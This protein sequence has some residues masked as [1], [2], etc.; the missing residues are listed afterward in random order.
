M[1]PFDPNSPA[2]T[3]RRGIVLMCVAVVF[4]TV[5]S[6]FVK[7]LGDGYPVAQIVFFRCL[8]GLLPLYFALRRA[9]GWA[10]L[11]TQRPGAHLFRVVVG[12]FALFIGFYALTLMPLADYFAYTYAAPLFATMLS[13]PVLGEKVGIRRWSAVTVGFIGVLIMLRPGMKSFDYATLAAIAT[14]FSYALAI[15]AVR[16]LARTEKSVATVFY[17][18]LAGMVLAGAMLPFDWRPPTAKEWALL[19]GIGLA[20]GIGQIVMAE[21]YRLA[22]PAVIAPFDYTSMVW[23]LAFGYLLFGDFPEPVVLLGA[24]IV[25]ASGVYIIYRETIRGVERPPLAPTPLK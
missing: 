6:T 1:S 17:F 10:A 2:Q 25:I 21:A 20:S 4:F 22:P 15:I 18:T 11:R 12:G 5:S 7:G 24:A 3:L 16:N 19:L 9:G 14:A 23:A 8:V 13:I